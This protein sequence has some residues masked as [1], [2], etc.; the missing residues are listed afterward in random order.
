[1]VISGKKISSNYI[2]IALLFIVFFVY[3]YHNTITTKPHSLH[4]WRQADC[5][6][7]ALNYYQGGMNF[8]APELM[9][10]NADDNTTGNNISEF[11]LLYYTVAIFYKVFG[12]HDFIFRLL[13]MLIFFIGLFYLFKLLKRHLEDDF[14][15][16]AVTFLIFSSALLVYYGNSYLPNSTALACV[17]IGWY[18]FFDFHKDKR[19]KKLYYSFGFFL[20]ATLFKITAAISPI[21]IMGYFLIEKAGILKKWFSNKVFTIELKKFLL[22]FSGFIGLSILWY[23][24]VFYYNDLHKTDYFGT[25]IWPLWELSKSEIMAVWKPIRLRWLGDFM[26]REVQLL[27]V[28]IILYLI[29]NIRKIKAFMTITSIMVFIGV[30]VYIILFFAVLGDHDYYLLNLFI[31]PVIVL[32]LGFETFK[33]VN[34]KWYKSIYV[35][36]GFS[37]FMVYVVYNTTEKNQI[38]HEGWYDTYAE[39][40]NLYDIAPYLRSLGI[41]QDDKVISLPDNTPSLSL[42]LM[43]QKGWTLMKYNTKKDI[44]FFISK[45]AKY[46]I[47][48]G[49]EYTHIN[50]FDDIKK[51][52]VGEKEDVFIYKLK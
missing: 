29:Y 25:R 49:M 19:D 38:R 8:F 20:L 40:E 36:I 9:Q 28:I 17:F 37:L 50:D 10:Q 45:G 5:A 32:I 30:V 42:Y 14:W 41:E 26:N 2:F 4:A 48:N 6:S 22:V 18:H 23:Y 21:A 1:M 33:N 13:N 31:L 44:D 7:M 11:P 43:N 39:Y 16:I 52:F 35:K 51:E 3:N 24:Y 47:I 15:A 46:L 34:P 12:H 27:L